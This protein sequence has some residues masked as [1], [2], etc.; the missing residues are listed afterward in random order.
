[1]SDLSISV[2]SSLL[3]KLFGSLNYPWRKRFEPKFTLGDDYEAG[4]VTV[5]VIEQG[6]DDAEADTDSN[7]F[8]DDLIETYSKE[9]KNSPT[10][11]AEKALFELLSPYSRGEI[12]ST[13]ELRTALE[14]DPARGDRLETFLKAL[15]L[16]A[17]IEWVEFEL[18]RQPASNLGN[19]VALTD[20]HFAVRARAEAC[21]KIFGKKHCLHFTTPW[22]RF[23]G[24]RAQVEL[25]VDQLR[26][27]G[28][29]SVRNIDFVITIKIL[30]IKFKVKIGV[31]SHINRYLADQQP[32]LADFSNIAIKIPGLDLTYTPKSVTVPGSTAATTVQLDGQFRR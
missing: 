3:T 8:V 13:S 23:E 32:V 16:S 5:D 9:S 27:I 10:N 29:P 25:V 31:T 21:V 2:D 30:G 26:I 20:L 14:N 11:A 12:R 4:E 22:I 24:E 18:A 17:G 6:G 19:P 7:L 28:R 1:M 15:D